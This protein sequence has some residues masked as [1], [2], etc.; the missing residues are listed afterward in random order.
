MEY[1]KLKE[2]GYYIRVQKG[3]Y[4]SIEHIEYSLAKDNSTTERI[5]ICLLNNKAA[6]LLVKRYGFIKR[7]VTDTVWL[8]YPESLD[9]SNNEPM[10][11]TWH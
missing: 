1:K 8:N 10:K 9:F 7:N 2:D 11:I 3:R 6:N 4:K 5:I